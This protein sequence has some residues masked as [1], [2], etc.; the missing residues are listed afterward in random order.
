MQIKRDR[1]EYSR[2]YYI[3]HKKKFIE[4]RK[5]RYANHKKEDAVYCRKYVSTKHGKAIRLLGFA[6][7]NAKRLNV[8]FNLSYDWLIKKLDKRVCEVTNQVFTYEKP[9]EGHKF[10][11]LAPS[12]DR[13]DNK[14]GYTKNNVVVCCWY[15]NLAKSTWN[16]GFF[17]EA[18]AVL[19]KGLKDFD[20]DKKTRKVT[21]HV[22]KIKH[23]KNTGLVKND[24]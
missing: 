21:R 22:K 18:I 14:K 11:P 24:A 13:L 16:I 19:H 15:I 12:L 10:N 20:Y 7:K 17:K 3:E 8:T 5:K 2:K 9:R 6:R 23:T 4:Y 1:T